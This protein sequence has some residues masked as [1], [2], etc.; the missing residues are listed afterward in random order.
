MIK[1][2]I[3]T[4]ACLQA[5]V[6]SFAQNE[7]QKQMM[8]ERINRDSK[9][10]G[11]LPKIDPI[12]SKEVLFKEAQI[13]PVY[14]MIFDATNKTKLIQNKN[15]YLVFYIGRLYCFL[16]NR[17]SRFF[18]NSPIIQS[19]TQFNKEKKE[20]SVVYFTDTFSFDSKYF[21]PLL[22]DKNMSFIIDRG[23]QFTASDYIDFKYGSKKKYKELEE[24]QTLREKLTH[25]DCNNS[26]K[27]NYVIFENNCPKDT[28][29]VL[30]TLINQIRLS[31]KDF[32]KSQELKLLERIKQKID[33][34]SLKEKQ[35][36][37]ALLA[38]K[39]ND[40]IIAS[41][42]LLSKIEYQKTKKEYKKPEGVYEF[43]VY[44]VSITNELLEIL[45]N[46][47]FVDYKKYNDLM[48]PIVET[49][50]G[51]NNNKYRYSYTKD[52]LEREGIIKTYN[53]K[54]YGDYI[55]KLVEECGCPFDET[56][57]SE[58]IIR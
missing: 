49:L 6:F 20:Y 7:A 40:S 8:Y 47:Q 11:I 43:G 28:T 10:S 33:P 51:Y 37:T 46:R 30:N 16:N 56:I 57:K 41:T 39:V 34:Y 32:T 23:N 22:T 3:F 25:V 35:L 31:T 42:L 1:K 14:K 55:K 15:Y 36:K 4:V 45:T 24:L 18:E 50:N 29:L 58:V 21:N 9:G 53:F 38:G 52:V 26:I 2:L 13:L 5:T 17:D 44:G 27:N 54:A 19:L 12:E 48:Y